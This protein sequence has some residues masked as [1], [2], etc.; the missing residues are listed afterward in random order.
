MLRIEELVQFAA[1]MVD[2]LIGQH[3]NTRQ[4]AVLAVERDLFV[5]Q[6]ILFPLLARCGQVEQAADRLVSGGTVAGTIKTS[7]KFWHP[8]EAPA[9]GKPGRG[10][11][12]KVP[13]YAPPAR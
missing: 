8:S 6:S 2:L 3:A 13:L 11:S 10:S 12:T 1:Q 5:R 7:R 9:P 4:V